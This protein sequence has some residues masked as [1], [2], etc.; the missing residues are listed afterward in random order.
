MWG[1]GRCSIKRSLSARSKRVYCGCGHRRGGDRA[2]AGRQPFV[3]GAE[4]LYYTAHQRVERPAVE[5]A[6]G[7]AG[8]TAGAVVRRKGNVESRGFGAGILAG[9]A[10]LEKRNRHTSRGVP[11]FYFSN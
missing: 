6:S 2:A 10:K 9:N 5:A 8:R 1:A 11:N 3:E 7:A 4:S